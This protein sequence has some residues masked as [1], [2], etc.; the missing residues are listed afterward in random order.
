MLPAAALRRGLANTRTSRSG[1]LLRNSAEIKA[2]NATT[3][4][5]KPALE[6]NEPHPQL[7]DSIT[8]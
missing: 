2:A 4:I 8:V 7:G 6:W 1:S 5:A 3:A